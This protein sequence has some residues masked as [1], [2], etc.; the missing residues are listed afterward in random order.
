MS[1]R[2]HTPAHIL[3]VLFAVA[4]ACAGQE[5]N[6]PV[7][8]APPVQP[9]PYSHKVHLARGLKCNDCHSNPDPGDRMTFAAASKCMACHVTIA[10]DRPAI[11]KLA[12]YAKSNEPIPW[13]RVYSVAARVYWSHRAHL[14]A[15]FKCEDCHGQV[16]DM[17][18]VAKVKDVTSMQGCI[19]CHH[20]HKAETGCAFCHEGK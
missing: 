5:E 13:V 7:Q 2:G 8:S 6:K 1:V 12:E 20:Q 17:E 3:V 14:E 18:V 15:G 10:K 19:D 9:L 4:M 11:Q 16:A